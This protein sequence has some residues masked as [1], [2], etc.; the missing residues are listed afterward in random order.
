MVRLNLL[1]ISLFALMISTNMKAQ[2]VSLFSQQPYNP[3]IIEKALSPDGDELS[4]QEQL[5]LKTYLARPDIIYA[6][7]S[8][9]EVSEAPSAL[10]VKPQETA[11][12]EIVSELP[13]KSVVVA[14][15]S[16]LPAEDVE[17]FVKKPSF[18][19]F[20]GDYYLQFLQNY[21]SDNWYKSGSSNY[22]MMGTATM[23]YNYDNKQKVK[24]DNKLELRL[25]FQTSEA[26]TVNKFK[27]SD[28]LIR[29]TSKLGI[30][31]HKKWYYTMQLI[32]NTQFARGLKDNKDF[33][34]SDFM[35]PFNLNVSLG[36]DYSVEALKKKLTGSV[37]LAPLAF[38]FKYV[39][40]RNLAP[41]FGIKGDHRTLEDFGSQITVDL[42]WK[43][44]ENLKWQT[45][46][47][48][49]TTYHKLEL[50]WENTISL[51]FN[52]YISTT[53]Y[54]YPRFDDSAKRDS[55]N[56]YWQFKEYLSFGFNYS[57]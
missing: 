32:A 12:T 48:T 54:L 4:Y 43:P 15:E 39:G 23:Q 56:G 37:H 35:S 38:N 5:L 55:N 20:S 11:M 40:R 44:T 50:E 17:M 51:Q 33:V 27:T 21:I 9:S 42:A 1:F 53:L 8:S 19:K 45:R 30:Q 29:Y 46:F 25:G 49:Y 10:D 16:E 14:E 7:N 36:M 3:N 2:N 6:L 18:W 31:A 28:D 26:D 22:S 24:W 57:I 52:K 47:Y 34:Y 41:N 13:K